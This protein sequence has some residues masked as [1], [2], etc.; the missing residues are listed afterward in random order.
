MNEISIFRNVEPAN[1]VYELE[2]LLH[3]AEDRYAR[4][5]AQLARIRAEFDALAA[6]RGCRTS[7]L[8]VARR[9]LEAASARC[10]RARR[11]IAQIEGQL[12]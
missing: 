12:D 10:E 1:D 4:A 9:Q 5:R 8:D 11:E 3:S 6:T 7:A 2:E